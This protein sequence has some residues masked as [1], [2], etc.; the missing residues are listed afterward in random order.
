M[1][2]GIIVSGLGKRQLKRI[3]RKVYFGIFD[4]WFFDARNSLYFRSYFQEHHHEIETSCQV[5]DSLP[6][7][8]I[9]IL[10]PHC[11][12][13]IIG[14]GGAILSYL[15]EG[16]EVFITYMTNGQKQGSQTDAREIIEERQ[17]EAYQVAKELGIPSENLFF[18]GG[19]DGDLIHSPIEGT[20]S[21]VISKVKP[22]TIF[23]PITLD[24]HVDHYATSKKLLQAVQL[25]PDALS[26]LTLYLYESQSP[27]TLKYA[28]TC[29]RITHTLTRKQELLRLFRSQPYPFK[30][31]IN[32]NQANG[33][34]LG[35]EEA[36]EAY[37]KAEFDTFEKFMNRYF[38]DDSEYLNRKERLLPNKHSASLIS[39]YNNC[40]EEKGILQ[41]LF[42]Q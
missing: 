28:N 3:I 18:L 38:E 6:G 42:K 33:K 12:D 24:N 22:D 23:L 20:L 26:G 1:M 9:M 21:N 30:F 37:L 15:K 16:K 35:P 39:S 40:L 5:V 4:S 27:L 29:L 17:K 32:L 7:E 31:V 14:C 19:T 13:E 8:R 34:Y 41:D 2:G 10:A 36:C 11:D 25:A